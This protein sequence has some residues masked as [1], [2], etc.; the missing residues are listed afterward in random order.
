MQPQA[1]CKESGPT[2]VLYAVNLA[3]LGLSGLWGCV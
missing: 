2:L 1:G 3:D